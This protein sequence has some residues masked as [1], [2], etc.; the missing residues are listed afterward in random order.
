MERVIHRV[1]EYCRRPGPFGATIREFTD[2]DF[3]SE[4][5]SYF[6]NYRYERYWDEDEQEYG[7]WDNSEVAAE[8]SDTLFRYRIVVFSNFL[9]LGNDVSRHY[10][11]GHW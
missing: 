5:K 1:S 10:T 2:L 9:T 3:R 6:D 11:R 7:E 8:A 4:R